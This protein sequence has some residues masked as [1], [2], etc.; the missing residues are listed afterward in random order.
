[1]LMSDLMSRIFG[2]GRSDDGQGPVSRGHRWLPGTDPAQEKRPRSRSIKA[3]AT[4]GDVPDL[5]EPLFVDFPMLVRSQGGFLK[6]LT[7]VPER[8]ALVSFVGTGIND[9]SRCADAAEAI[10]QLRA[11]APADGGALMQVFRQQLREQSPGHDFLFVHFAGDPL[12]FGFLICAL[13]T[14]GFMAGWKLG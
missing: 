1:M 2:R 9:P 12:T 13:S 11:M 7:P 5:G 4:T 14:G 3:S 6:G 10:D 8:A